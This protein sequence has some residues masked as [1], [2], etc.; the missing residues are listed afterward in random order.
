M[1]TRIFIS[2]LPAALTTGVPTANVGRNLLMLP[3]LEILSAIGL[4]ELFSWLRRRTSFSLF[5]S[6]FLF[7]VVIMGFEMHLFLKDYFITTPARLISTWGTPLKFILPK[8]ARLEDNVEKIIVTDQSQ[9]YMYLLFYTKKDPKWFESQTKIRHPVVGYSKLG[10]YE[11]R[12]INWEIDQFIPNALLV[13]T[14]AE[15]PENTSAIYEYRNE[16][17]NE[18]LMRVVRTAPNTL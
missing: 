18:L 4:Y 15:L 2:P 9:A 16:T 6:F 1:D 11:F 12:K 7:F 10:K 8:V 13:G 3:I 17:T 14:P 5:V